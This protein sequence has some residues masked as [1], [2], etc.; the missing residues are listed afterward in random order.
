MLWS[1]PGI[2]TGLRT[3]FLR[4]FIWHE[5]IRVIYSM[6]HIP[7]SR[8]TNTISS[9]LAL[10]FFLFSTPKRISAIVQSLSCVWLFVI[11]WTAARQASLPFTN[12]LSLLKLMS[13]ESVMPS[14]YLILCLPL[15]LPPSIFPIIKVFSNDSALPIRWPKY[16]IHVIYF[17]F[18][19]C[20][21]SILPYYNVSSMRMD[22]FVHYNLPK[23]LEK[24]LAQ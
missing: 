6:I 5:K 20:L 9:F 19:P 24:Y 16:Q 22:F 12:S 3:I 10:S 21:S 15:L 7:I 2:C 1:R 23:D 18:L 17:N 4:L 13:I 8:I 11:P 14:N